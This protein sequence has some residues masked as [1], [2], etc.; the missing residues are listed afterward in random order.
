LY[1]KYI[2]KKLYGRYKAKKAL[3]VVENYAFAV[4]FVASIASS[5]ALNFYQSSAN[6]LQMMDMM[7]IL[8]IVYQTI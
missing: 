8:G 4:A 1:Q 2:I 5:Y 6:A 3:Y 7:E